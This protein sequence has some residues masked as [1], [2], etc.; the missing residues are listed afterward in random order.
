M[1]HS[2]RQSPSIAGKR[3]IE[4]AMDFVSQIHP[5]GW[6]G[7][8]ENSWWISKSD[9][10]DFLHDVLLEIE[11]LSEAAYGITFHY[12]LAEAE[13]DEDTN[14]DNRTHFTASFRMNHMARERGIDIDW[15]GDIESEDYQRAIGIDGLLNIAAQS[16]HKQGYILWRNLTIPVTYCKKGQSRYGVFV[17]AEFEYT[18]HITPHFASP[19]AEADF[20]A[21]A[22]S[23]GLTLC[24]YEDLEQTLNALLEQ[25]WSQDQ[26]QELPDNENEDKQEDKQADKQQEDENDDDDEIETIDKHTALNP[27]PGNEPR[28]GLSAA[29]NNFDAREVAELADA[30]VRGDTARMDELLKQG[31]DVNGKGA[32]CAT[33]LE[34]AYINNSLV[35]IRALLQAGADPARSDHHGYTIVHWAATIEDPRM[36]DGLLEIGLDPNLRNPL[37]GQ[38]PLFDAIW[39]GRHA[40]FRA[41]IAAGADVNVCEYKQWHFQGGRDFDEHAYAR[42]QLSLLIP[43]GDSPLHRATMLG[44]MEKALTLLQAGAN[45]HAR[46]A[47]GQTFQSYLNGRD[48]TAAPEDWL[49]AKAD[50]EDWLRGHGI[51]LE[52]EV[53]PDKVAEHAATTPESEGPYGWQG[54][55]QVANTYP[56]PH[57]RLTAWQAFGNPWVAALA[58]AVAMGDTETV[59]LLGALGIDLNAKGSLADGSQ[60][61]L[62]QWVCSV[63]GDVRSIDGILAWLEAGGSE[64]ITGEDE[65]DVKLIQY[66]VAHADCDHEGYPHLLNALLKAG[67]SPNLRLRYG[68]TA[69]F[70]AAQSD[71]IALFRALTEAGANLEAANTDGETPLIAIA[72]KWAQGDDDTSP[73]TSLLR[74]LNSGADPRA[75]D[76][77]GNTFQ[78]YIQSKEESDAPDDI[79]ETRQQITRWL[80]EH[81][82]PI[83]QPL[84]EGW[85]HLKHP[86]TGK[87]ALETFN[88]PQLAQL[89]HAAARKDRPGL[90]QLLCQMDVATLPGS[91]QLE[92]LKW[93]A[94][95]SG[96]LATLLEAGCIPSIWRSYTQDMYERLEYADQTHHGK[97]VDRSGDDPDFCYELMRSG[98]G[99]VLQTLL[100]AGICPDLRDEHDE[101]TL[102]YRSI[103]ENDKVGFHLL[104]A[105]GADPNASESDND[106]DTP[107]HT[108][109]RAH[110]WLITNNDGQYILP[111][112]KA[113][114]DPQATNA[115]GN[116]FQ[117]YL[118][119]IDEN[120]APKAFIRNKRKIEAW[121]HEHGVE[122]EVEVESGMGP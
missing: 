35:G 21:L 42:Q 30:A 54:E 76:R 27:V 36:L 37:N 6:E 48:E 104:L 71:N 61:N 24:R 55:S 63:V 73:V 86:H 119:A 29:Y 113:G 53:G 3:Y 96:D 91:T 106:R 57:Y 28:W 5:R 77:Q 82:V 62:L 23:L 56:H 7:A 46:N 50:L 105:A 101:Q 89:V 52:S 109:A 32:P 99:R 66:I 67:L 40:Q 9:G 117:Y 49:Q 72:K 14:D 69:I 8:K 64:I 121:L 1:Q 116:T 95:T 98:N 31:A 60:V 58:E 47:F 90:N 84:K 85:Q 97:D 81:G 45:P 2:P 13:C 15:G 18:C 65:E 79:H 39:T 88:S 83:L 102:L 51:A 38:T 110:E 122:V 108:A 44:D 17:Y 4:R 75:V 78:Y 115:D 22:T 118:N 111:L 103:T 94:L 43:R 20:L 19:Q 114:A 16:L 74:L 59:R 80:K 25:D 107:L 120:T 112:L 26:Q 33:P 92:L 93:V 11:D 41:L 12:S 34:W 87:T 10:Q 100:E 68:R 70:H